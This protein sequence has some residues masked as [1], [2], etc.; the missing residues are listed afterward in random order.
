MAQTRGAFGNLVSPQFRQVIMETGRAR[1]LEYPFWVNV[2]TMD[3]N[4]VTDLQAAGLG[5]MPSKPEGTQFVLDEMKLGGTKEYLAG[6]FGAAVEITWEMW[7]DDLYG[8]MRELFR[9]LVLSSA[10]RQEIDAHFPLN[11]AFNTSVVGFTSG[12]SLCDTAHVGLDGVSRANRPAVDIAFGITGVQNALIRFENLTNERGRRET[13]QPVMAVVS[14]TNKFVARELLGSG[15][16]PFSANNEIN[17]LIEE[18][19]SWMVSH[20]LDTATN[21]FLLAAKGVHDINFL[22]RDQP[23]ADSFDD[24]W[25][26]NAIFTMYQRHTKGHG[27]WRGIDGSTG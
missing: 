1:T 15:G 10:E 4:S 7:R 2:D 17:A 24:P 16:K 12:E 19:L 22:W 11:N 21:W 9:E 8:P 14:P 26:K 3:W 23:I 25:T 13:L 6:P 5:S 18:D 27:K 20:Y